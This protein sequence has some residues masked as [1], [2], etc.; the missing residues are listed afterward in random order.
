MTLIL[1]QNLAIKSE[2]SRLLAN[3]FKA[4]L[5]VVNSFTQHSCLL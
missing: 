5:V 2:V 1:S 3:L 4:K